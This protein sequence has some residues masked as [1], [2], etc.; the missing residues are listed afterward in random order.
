MEVDVVVG[1]LD[2]GGLV[3]GELGDRRHHLARHPLEPHLR[4][5]DR[6]GELERAVAPLERLRL[7]PT[8]ERAHFLED[9]LLLEE[10]LLL[11]VEP[12]VEQPDLRRQRLRLRV[13][14]LELAPALL[15]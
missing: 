3:H 12:L 11:V 2:R 15:V 6:L 9:E 1:E 14:P 10:L 8:G 13:A 5:V 4:L 7:E